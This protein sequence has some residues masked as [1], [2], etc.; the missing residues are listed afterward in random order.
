MIGMWGIMVRMRG[1]R[2]GM[3]EMVVGMSGM[4]GISSSSSSS[5]NLYL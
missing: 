1:I 3:R 4:R 5:S 2:A